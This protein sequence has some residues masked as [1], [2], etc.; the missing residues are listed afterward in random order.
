MIESGVK[1]VC[2]YG[3]TEFCVPTIVG[4]PADMTAPLEPNP[5]WAWLRFSED[6]I[7]RMEPQGDGTY[8]LVVVVSSG[9]IA[10]IF[11]LRFG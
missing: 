6:P 7:I 3:G 5:H 8:E 4:N 2:A 11:S 1:L 10:R 9:I